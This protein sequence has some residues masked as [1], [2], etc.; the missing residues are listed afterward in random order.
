MKHKSQQKTP[1]SKPLASMTSTSRKR[2]REDEDTTPRQD[3]K[4]SK[5]NDTCENCQWCQL[6]AFE[7]YEKYPIIITNE[8]DNVALPET[9][10]FIQHS[11]YREGVE[12]AEDAFL[13]GC[14]CEHPKDCEEK[15]CSCT[16]DVEKPPGTKIA[17]HKM[18][19]QVGTGYRNCLKEGFLNQRQAIFECNDKCACGPSCKNRVVERG[20]KLPLE[21]FKTS[22]DRGW[23]MK[24]LH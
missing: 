24:Q 23:G 15:G 17:A 13:T 11:I 3:A 21:I 1:Q 9:F 20:R 4:R 10:R 8:V 5:H 12:P 19:Y 22:D 18:Q 2:E 16:E 6:A 14:E 7:D